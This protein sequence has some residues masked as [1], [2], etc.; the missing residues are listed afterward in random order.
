MIHESIENLLLL[1]NDDF[2]IDASVC[3]TVRS[4]NTLL[5]ALMLLSTVG[6]G[7]I[8]VLDNEQKL[9][10]VVSM[11]L[12]L[13]GIKDNVQYNWDQLADH[14]VSEVM[15]TRIGI[16]RAPVVL[17]DVL[18]ELAN[19][20]FACVVNQEGVFKGI[21]TRKEILTRVNFLAHEFHNYY[22]VELKEEHASL[23]YNPS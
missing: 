1:N 2:V 9:L 11:P 15:N 10:G 19:H 6:Y 13:N 20:N 23:S 21:I 12:I 4:E 16:V 3:A 7:E 17:E 8:P 18:H 5:H 14:K 22:N